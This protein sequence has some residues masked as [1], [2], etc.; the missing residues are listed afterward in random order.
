MGSHFSFA[1]QYVLGTLI[2]AFGLWAGHRHGAWSFRRGERRD[3]VILAC[4]LLAYFMVQGLL[5][6]SAAGDAP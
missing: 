6:L 1:Y 2:F 3:A 4:T 5:Q